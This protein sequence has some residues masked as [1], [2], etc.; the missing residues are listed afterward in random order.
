GLKYN[1]SG[2]DWITE[3]SP[4]QPCLLA[5]GHADAVTELL[6]QHRD[7]GLRVLI[8]TPGFVYGPG[9]ILASMVDQLR[10]REY[11]V[12]GDGSNFWSLVHV[13][14]LAV[15]YAL[16]LERGQPGGHWFA[17]DDRPI[18]RREM[19]A[20][21]ARALKLPRPGWIPAWLLG[22]YL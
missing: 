1:G 11:R 22:L 15:L 7:R 12:M 10:K 19:V 20:L 16:A 14:D 3:D 21:L 6:A 8:I 5:K 18:R 17:A 9:G 2:D 4:M 13:D